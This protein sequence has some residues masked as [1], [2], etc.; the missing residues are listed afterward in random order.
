MNICGKEVE[1]RVGKGRNKHIWHRGKLGSDVV[2]VKA[3]ANPMKRSE[4]E[5]TLRVG[6]SLRRG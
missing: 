6:L 4:P 5:I 1:G 3:S 2:S